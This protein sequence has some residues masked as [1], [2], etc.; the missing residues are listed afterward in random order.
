MCLG[1]EFGIG[2]VVN[3]DFGF[4]Y[5]IGVWCCMGGLFAVVCAVILI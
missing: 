1:F 3:F 4:V 5:L 2:L